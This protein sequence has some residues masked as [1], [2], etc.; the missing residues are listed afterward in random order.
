M[1]THLKTAA[2]E[3][4][5]LTPQTLSGV[6]PGIAVPRYDRRAVQI[7]IVHFGPGAFHR[8]HQAWY[9][10]ALLARDPRWAICGAELRPPGF[11]PALV[12]QDCL[13]TVAE[14]DADIHFRV[15]GSLK[16][17]RSAKS[18]AEGIFAR[19][20]QKQI[21]LVT[22]TVTEKGYCL[23]G[24]GALDFRHPDIVHD[25]AHPTQPVSIVG[26]VT[27]GLAR[28]KTIGLPPF[29]AMSCDN[30]VSNGEKLHAAVL[31][32]ADARG[33]KDLASW[34]AGEVKF[35]STMVDSITPAAD[36]ALKHKVAE[37]VGLSD[38][39]PVQREN[40]L[41]WVV[42]DVLGDDAPD[43]ASVGAS[44]TN[45]VRAFELAKLRLLN[46]THSTLAYVGL[47]MGYDF[48][49]EAMKDPRLAGFVGTMMREDIAPTLRKTQGLNFETY[50][51][52][53]LKR[54][55]NPTLTH[56]LYQIASDGT[57]KLPY[58]I[59]GTIR[60]ALA[61]GRPIDR[62]A[63]PIAA[64]MRF[65]MREAKAGRTLADPMSETLAK[66][67]RA[68][69]GE[70]ARDLPRFLALGDVFPKNLATNQAFVAATAKAYDRFK[71]DN[72]LSD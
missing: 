47:L 43:V 50:S 34:I 40:F 23:D 21:R 33:D 51:T 57:Q 66:V 6:L 31:K 37:A 49:A 30:M 14:L 28:R 62:L 16:E 61:A 42:E 9:M 58:R 7:G 46:G 27:E 72:F 53:I 54:Y 8:G 3:L 68:C 71:T 55:R 12:P 63:V 67:G 69:I 22:M 29:I 24:S 38:E 65:V 15:I 11:G 56:K 36:E 19:L 18:D 17:Y 1:S 41:Q 20:T 4:R 44:L 60:D 13:Y 39:A 48:V 26:W 10:D 35:P 25:L 64:W 5:R 2:P 32:F 45:D 70:A 59:L 52:D